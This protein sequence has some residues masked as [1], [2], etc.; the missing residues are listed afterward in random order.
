MNAPALYIPAPG[1]AQAQFVFNADQFDSPLDLPVAALLPRGP[2]S[3]LDVRIFDDTEA[4]SVGFIL[5]KFKAGIT[6]LRFMIEPFPWSL[7]FNMYFRPLPEG[8]GKIGP[9]QGPLLLK[10]RDVP[11]EE[12]AA[13]DAAWRLGGLPYYFESLTC[14]LLDAS[15]L[16]P[17]KLSGMQIQLARVP[18]PGTG[19]LRLFRMEVL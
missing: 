18:E 16:E 4:Q 9:W 15:E 5:P 19:T 17:L 10:L 14:N 6:A 13:L 1:Q 8:E 7:A 11:R 2:S 12:A 3:G